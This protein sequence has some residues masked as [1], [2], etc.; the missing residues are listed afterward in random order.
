MHRTVKYIKKLR[1]RYAK[2]EAGWREKEYAIMADAMA[3][4]LELRDDPHALDEFLELAGIK[5]PSGAKSRKQDWITLEVI[6]YVIGATSQHAR[7]LAWKRARALDYLHDVKEVPVDKIA[8]AIKEAGGI[9]ALVNE[10]AAND[11]R[12][13]KSSAAKSLKRGRVTSDDQPEEN[14]NQDDDE[15]NENDDDDE[16][17][18]QDDD[19]QQD[20]NEGQADDEVRQEDNDESEQD[21]RDQDDDEVDDDTMVVG[22]SAKL[23][24]KFR[25]IPVNMKVRLIGTRKN[26]DNGE[27][28]FEVQKVVKIDK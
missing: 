2:E 10:A 1:R 6:A 23:R 9:E 3:K 5:R 22:I 26:D 8:K 19:E 14:E 4:V 24:K 20:S 15:K 27:P 12:K 13:V 18:E 21:D 16:N 7:D 25:K 28:S 11:P 17:G